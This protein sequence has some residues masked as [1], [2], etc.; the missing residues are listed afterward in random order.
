MLMP[1]I[2]TMTTV[3]QVDTPAITFHGS[4]G[5]GGPTIEGTC[6]TT[7]ATQSQWFIN[8]Y[9][10]SH[11]YYCCS[12]SLKFVPLLRLD[13]RLTDRLGQQEGK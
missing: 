7:L 5:G 4:P 6:I 12:F 1:T 8:R 10:Y 9:A 11:C 2:R 13:K 3:T